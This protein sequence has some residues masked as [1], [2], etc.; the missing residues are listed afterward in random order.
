[1][2][3]T[4]VAEKIKTQFFVSFFFFKNRTVKI[5]RKCKKKKWQIWIGHRRQS[6]TSCAQCMLGDLGY[7][8]TQNT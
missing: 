3:Q 1:M 4:K 5:V 6:K 8:H 2:F 7:R